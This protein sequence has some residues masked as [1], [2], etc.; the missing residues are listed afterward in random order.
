MIADY[1][2]MLPMSP[3]PV[4]RFPLSDHPATALTQAYEQ[5]DAAYRSLSAAYEETRR[6]YEQT[7]AAYESRDRDYMLVFE[8]RERFR[9]ELEAMRVRRW[10]ANM[11]SSLRSRARRG[12][13]QS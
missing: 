3:Q 1:H 11:V 10:A 4:A 8:E 7:R 2:R 6:A 9:T 5:L 13:P 12:E